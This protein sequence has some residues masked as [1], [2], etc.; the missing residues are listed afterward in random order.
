MIAEEIDLFIVYMQ[1]FRPF[2]E[3]EIFSW[4]DVVMIGGFIS[5][6]FH[7]QR[8]DTQHINTRC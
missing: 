7:D 2:L 8:E 1:K 3:I 5:H 4:T 6:G